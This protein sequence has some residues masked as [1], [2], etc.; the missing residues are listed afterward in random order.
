MSLM[1]PDTVS[2]LAHPTQRETLL[3]LRTV[4]CSTAEEDSSNTYFPC[5]G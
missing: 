5:N 1:E 4:E 3:F 2:I